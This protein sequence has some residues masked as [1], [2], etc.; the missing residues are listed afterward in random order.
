MI[1]IV[2]SVIAG[3]FAWILLWFVGETILSAI[4]SGWFGTHQA[5]FQAAIENGSPF[6]ADSTI[7][8][9]HIALGSIAAVISGFLAAVIAGESKRA[10]L[11]LGLLLLALGLLKMAMSWALVPIWYHAI[12]TA[13]LFPMAIIGGKLR[14]AG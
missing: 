10:P 11:I 1:R 5:A 6:T 9:I 13:I 2:L 4:S 3:F 14:K 12:F 7:L 8:F